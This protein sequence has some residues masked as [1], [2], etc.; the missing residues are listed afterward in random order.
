[1][2]GLWEKEQHVPKPNTLKKL[3]PEYQH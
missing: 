2:L 1:M 3:A